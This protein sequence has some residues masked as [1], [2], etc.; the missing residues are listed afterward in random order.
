[1]K[2]LLAFTI[3]G[4][5]ALVASLTLACS[6]CRFPGFP[7]LGGL[8]DTTKH[9]ENDKFSFDYPGGWRTLSE[10]WPALQPSNDVGVADPGSST[11]FEKYLTSVT[12][13]TKELPLDSS[14]E[15]MMAET[16]PQGEGEVSVS[17]TIVDGVAAYERVYEKFRGEPLHWIREIWLQKGDRIYII[18]CW[19]TPGRVEKAQVD[20]N[21]IIESFHVK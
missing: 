14:L 16:D 20:F 2:R 3:W 4:I 5:A 7:G 18:S 19:T 11:M 21:M 12:I 9:F 13:L 15:A 10:S 8:L 6:I 1:M 17:T